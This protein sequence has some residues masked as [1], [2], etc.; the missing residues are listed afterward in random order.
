MQSVLAI[1]A[2]KMQKILATNPRGL[3]LSLALSGRDHFF[4]FELF[5][6]Y[7]F[8]IFESQHDCDLFGRVE[9]N[10]LRLVLKKAWAMVKDDDKVL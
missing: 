3:V 8:V 10:L 1:C 4:V 5:R 9:E 7:K 2:T 6:I